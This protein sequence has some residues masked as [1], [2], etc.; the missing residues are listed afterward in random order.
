MR[1]GLVGAPAPGFPAGMC[2]ANAST[3][4]HGA[5]PPTGPGPGPAATPSRP[6]SQPDQRLGPD[7]TPVRGG[8]HKKAPGRRSPQEPRRAAA[9]GL[10]PADRAG[11][12]E[13]APDPAS[14]RR[15][16]PPGGQGAPEQ[17]AP[18]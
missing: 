8:P 4:V 2:P 5:P 7:N 18:A 17:Q 10:G 16:R 12:A 13:G 3:T 11:L 9:T 6:G 1:G 14:A 15:D